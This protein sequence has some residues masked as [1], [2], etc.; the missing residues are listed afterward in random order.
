[1]TRLFGRPP[2]VEGCTNN[3]LGTEHF[4]IELLGDCESPTSKARESSGVVNTPRN[5]LLFAGGV[6]TLWTGGALR[7]P[8]ERRRAAPAKAETAPETRSQRASSV[9]EDLSVR[10][11]WL[12]ALIGEGAAQEREVVGETPNRAARLQGLAR[13]NEQPICLP[14][15]PPRPQE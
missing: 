9:R 11:P 6:Q 8:M 14:F 5:N 3:F 1:M 10:S 12:A 13:P 4:L 15:L 2:T 7:S